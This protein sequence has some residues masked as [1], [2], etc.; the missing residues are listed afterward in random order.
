MSD[1][2][3]DLYA[4]V[5]FV[6]KDCTAD[7][8]AAFS[9]LELSISQ[10]KLLHQLDECTDPITLKA[11]GELIGVSLPTASRIVEDLVRRGFVERHEDTH[12]RRMKRVSVTDHGST[13]VRRLNAA[14]LN[15]FERFT[16]TLTETER[17]ALAAALEQLTARAEIASCRPEETV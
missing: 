2:A 1:L 10:V 11:A 3:R 7:L 13:I 9:T 4:L 17:T 14:R 15:G 8:F 5:L 16:Q 6:H 12:D